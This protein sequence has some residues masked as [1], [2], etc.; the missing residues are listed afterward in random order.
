MLRPTWPQGVSIP[1]RQASK[2]FHLSI[3]GTLQTPPNYAPGSPQHI[4]K[5]PR[6][7]PGVQTPACKP[8]MA[9]VGLAKLT[10]E[11][12]ISTDTLLTSKQCLFL[13][14]DCRFTVPIVKRRYRGPDYTRVNEQ[15]K[16]S[17]L[18]TCMYMHE[19]S[20]IIMGEV[21]SLHSS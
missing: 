15:Y 3:P 8:P 14:D 10:H 20:Q 2:P 4:S 7:H 19:S 13:A 1:S 21:Q 17:I 5:M 12:S 9:S 18:A 11:S 6:D 16:N